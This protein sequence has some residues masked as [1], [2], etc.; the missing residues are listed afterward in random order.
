MRLFFGAPGSGKT[1]RILDEIRPRLRSGRGFLLV[2]PTSTM[3]EHVANLLAREGLPVRPSSV[4]TMAAFAQTV[5]PGAAPASPQVLSLLITRILAARKPRAFAPL[6]DRPGLAPALR[7]AIEDLAN[8]GC[9]SLQ[10]AGLRRLGVH[11]GDI[12]DALGLVYEDLEKELQQRDL[13]LR[14]AQLEAAASEL[15]K[16][17][18]LDVEDVYLDGFFSFTPAELELLKA[19]NA[20]ARVTVALPEWPG[21]AASRTALLQMGA[22][23][24]RLQV[25][26]RQPATTLT[27]APDA[28]REA[29]EIALRIL[30]LHADGRAFREMAVVLRS[31][32]PYAPLLETT[33]ERFGI[34]VRSY[35]AT[36]LETHPVVRFFSQLVEAL[37]SDWELE[38]TA[39]ALLMPVARSSVCAAAPRFEYA[40]GEALPGKG[41]DKLQTIAASFDGAGPLLEA[42]D[43]LRG[44]DSAWREPAAPAEWASRLASLVSLVAPPRP[45]SA[46]VPAELRVYRAR[47]EALQMFQTT[48]D[49]VASLL[50][51]EP[52]SLESFY[53]SAV[54]ALAAA[55]LRVGDHRRET[56]HLLDVFEARQWELPVVFVCGLLEGDFPRHPSPDPLIGE[57]CRIRLRQSGVP[58]S[59]RAEREQ[60][61]RFLLTFAQTRATDRLYLSWPVDDGKGAPTLRS[62]ALDDLGL[63]RVEARRASIVPSAPV[64]PAPFG[65]LRDEQLLAW[66]TAVHP[67][68]S[69]TALDDFLQCPF[70]YFA[71]KTLELKEAPKR[72]A[73]RLDFA[74][75]GSLV[76]RSIA[77][78]HTGHEEM[79]SVFERNWERTL[80]RLRIPPSYRIEIQHSHL[81]QELCDYASAFQCDPAWT[82]H[83]ERP[84]T[85]EVEGVTVNGRAD[86]VDI[87]AASECRAF[88]FK[89]STKSGIERKTKEAGEMRSVQGGIYMAAL[90]EAGLK[91]LSFTYIG[92]RGGLREKTVAGGPEVESHI[93]EA[94]RTAGQAILQIYQGEIAVRPADV[95]KCEWCAFRDTC[96]VTGLPAALAAEA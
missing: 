16:Q 73:E 56:V 51:P 25:I 17:H 93:E 31:R 74:A 72:P 79:P 35:F 37:L 5:S 7:D 89:Y 4:R 53:L 87:N 88:D 44:L 52:L 13:R 57:E 19:L 61:D 26:R 45:N 55:D 46:V 29:E 54:P 94:L 39:E 14:P 18:G 86:R 10:W 24:E 43:A 2:V 60:T 66:L 67:Q 34:P 42:I 95:A 40:V 38:R 71:G 85:L 80:R 64:N 36:P 12:T 75:V 49:V 11:R 65:P 62:F 84:V 9:D 50:P 33:F 3:A 27:A 15:R 63:T 68:Q 6:L 92:L 69:V 90:R 96:R 58:V 41:L 83:M 70:R 1:T 28:R 20:R 8:A 30:D 91:P 48:L 82:V 32:A 76:H 22:H 23:E 77:E 78:W 81:L 21:A 47:A 59:S